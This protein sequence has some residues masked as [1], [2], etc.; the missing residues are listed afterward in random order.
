M[1][2]TLIKDKQLETPGGGAKGDTGVGLKG[3]TGVGAKGDTGSGVKGDTGIG[4][5]GDTGVPGSSSAKGDTGVGVQGDTGTGIQGDTGIPGSAASKGDTGV[6]VQGDTGVGVKGDTGSGGGGSGPTLLRNIWSADAP[7]TSPTT[8]DDEFDDA[9][10]DG[11]WTEFDPNNILTISESAA[12][13]GVLFSQVTRSGDNLVGLYQTIP[14]GNFTIW[15]RI[16]TL[17][18]QKNFNLFGLALWENPADVSKSL[19]T[20]NLTV[21]ATNTLWEI[22]KWTDHNTFATPAYLSAAINYQTHIYLRVRRN[23]TNYYH[24]YSTDGISWMDFDGAAN[25]LAVPTEFGIFMS[26][27][28]TGITMAMLCPFFRYVASDVGVTGIL[29][30]NLVGIYS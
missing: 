12:Y 9:S 27:V 24:G 22:C 25:G 7:P 1:G 14:S 23:G 26:N 13:K 28:N 4:I 16:S 21:N 5:Q 6:G 3:D 2:A 20:N 15:T 10:L 30:G 19:L 17:A 29:T 18:L 11:K 8:Q